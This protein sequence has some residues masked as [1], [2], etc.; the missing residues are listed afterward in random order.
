MHHESLAVSRPGIDL[1]TL[2]TAKSG[3]RVSVVMV[4]AVPA[5]A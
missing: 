5:L 2:K 3:E 4:V 1:T